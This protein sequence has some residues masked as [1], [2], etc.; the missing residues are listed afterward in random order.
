MT[1][2]VFTKDIVLTFQKPTD[3]H[4]LIQVIT[5]V[6]NYCLWVSPSIK[7]TFI[8]SLHLYLFQ[9]KEAS[10]LTY[11]MHI[12]SHQMGLIHLLFNQVSL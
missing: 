4:M 8:R 1:K 9:H 10:T 2:Y 6:Q 5:M 11:K 3:P 7:L 12:I